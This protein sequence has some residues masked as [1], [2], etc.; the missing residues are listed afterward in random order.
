MAKL[1]KCK[2]CGHDISKKAAACPN[3]GRKLKAK[4]SGCAWLALTVIVF[5]VIAL[6]VLPD[7][8][9]RRPKPKVAVTDTQLERAI[10]QSDDYQTHREAFLEASRS[11]VESRK[12]TLAELKEIGG[13]VKSQSYKDQPVYFTY[14]GGSKVSNRIMLDASSGKI[15]K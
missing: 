6:I 7:S 4:T 12:C 14:C 10:S 1:I 13:F 3:C 5:T 9:P 11:L 15:F 2:D 8:G